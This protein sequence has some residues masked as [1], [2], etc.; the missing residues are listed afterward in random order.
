MHYICVLIIITP[1][2]ETL[3][4]TIY[5][6][7]NL[8]LMK[9]TKQHDAAT[10]MLHCGYSNLRVMSSAGFDMYTFIQETR[11]DKSFNFEAAYFIMIGCMHCC[12]FKKKEGIGQI[13][14]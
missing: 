6:K 12:D 3:S 5:F 4:C 7:P 8:H 11:G 9:F 1:L 13:L 10:T 14:R 2:A